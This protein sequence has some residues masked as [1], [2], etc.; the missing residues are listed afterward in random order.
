MWIIKEYAKAIIALAV[1]GVLL[2]FQA[3]YEFAMLHKSVIQMEP[4]VSA[5]SIYLLREAPPSAGGFSHE[6]IVFFSFAADKGDEVF[7]SRVVGLPG[8]RIAIR[9]GKLVRNGEE[10]DETYLPKLFGGIHI[11]ET[12]VPRGHL[13]VLN[14]DREQPG[15][16]RSLGPVPWTA[17]YGKV[18][19]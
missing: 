9:D 16:S 11:S 4:A 13:F 8:E 14:D 12:V 10:T 7:V 17:V 6:D 18:R 2:W 3:T 1:L 19:R 5:G 15:D